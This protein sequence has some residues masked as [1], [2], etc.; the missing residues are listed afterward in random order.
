VQALKKPSFPHTPEDLRQDPNY[1]VWTRLRSGDLAARGE[2]VALYTPLVRYVFGRMAVRTSGAMDL[3]DVFAAG[4][5]GLLHAIDRFNPEQGVRF[6]TYALQ[7]IRGAI[8][9]AIRTLSPLSRGAVRRNRLLDASISELTQRLGREPRQEEL[10]DELGVDTTELRHMLLDSTHSIV[11]LDTRSEDDND[12][13]SLGE[14]LHD[15]DTLET[16]DLAFE[17]DEI[18]HRLNTALR[19]LPERDQLVL[20]HYYKKELTLRE[21]SREIKVSESRVS[22]I[23]SGAVVKL[24]NL[25][26][27]RQPAWAA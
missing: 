13:S 6:E 23:R 8:I 2:L 16:D 15:P 10:A 22:Q 14:L 17:P 27:P 9:D 11:S 19:S 12:R 21:I 25:L 5:I 3:D 20:N 18:L 26:G 4:T 1:P 24:S 7:R